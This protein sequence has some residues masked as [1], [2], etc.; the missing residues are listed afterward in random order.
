MPEDAVLD[1]FR[2]ESILK[3][4]SYIENLPETRELSPKDVR[5]YKNRTFVFG[6]S[7]RVSFR[8]E[9][10]EFHILTE[11]SFPFSAPRIALANPPDFLAWP[12]LEKDGVLCILHNNS[13]VS[14]HD[15]VG[16]FQ[17]MFARAV[18][19]VE[20]SLSNSN[21]TD[22]EMEFDTYWRYQTADR[23]NPCQSL[24]SVELGNR[25]VSYW[26]G[27]KL[28]VVA[29]NGAAIKAWLSHRYQQESES[30]VNAGT[31]CDAALIWLPKALHPSEYPTRAGD[32]YKILRTA[33]GMTTVAELVE[34]TSRNIRIIL[35]APTPNGPVLAGVRIPAPDGKDVMDRKTDPLRRGFRPGR[36]PAQ[37][38]AQ[39]YLN[40]SASLVRFGITRIDHDW[41]HGRGHDPHQSVLKQKA[42]VVLGCGSIGAAVA[43][44]LARS[45]VGK[46]L[47]ID[48]ELLEW[49]NISR[50]ILGAALVGHNKALALAE[51][52]QANYPHLDVKG[53]DL[54][55]VTL[56][57]TQPELLISCDLIASLTANWGVE[58]AL[59]VWYGKRNQRPNLVSGWTEAHAMAGH[60][61]FTG[62]K[63]CLRC[64]FDS[65]GR[66]RF[67][68]TEWPVEP[69]L[70][71]PAC[72]AVFAPY[73][74]V[75]VGSTVT[76]VSSLIL[77][78]L[79][80]ST[81]SPTHRFW[82]GARSLLLEAGGRWS[83]GWK[84]H[85][86]F[87]ESG[88]I[89]VEQSWPPET[90]CSSCSAIE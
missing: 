22:F 51:H 53:R 16:V 15:P 89:V 29:E 41:I 36:V 34:E 78:C 56:L 12:H 3:L 30:I 14:A 45:G 82:V 7:V 47:L 42:V 13:N 55:A 11:P 38:L 32:L 1:R 37:L 75:D 43:A 80:G 61:V 50:H 25:S 27:A 72:G 86:Q 8:E 83:A 87:R 4:G 17:N 88:S 79:L 70:Q 60:A 35:A 65:A 71:E 26:R 90:L 54:S 57:R 77:D 9:I 52:L 48:N 81:K 5:A 73:G 21:S 44:N 10:Y 59:T 39:R 19:L 74:A 18:K 28:D 40:S 46:L 84:V 68:V 76:L 62:E 2:T 23:V 31:D 64:G 58:Q 20:D 33:G 49:P 24:L 6:W 66:P 67:Q 63:S 69:S 85:P